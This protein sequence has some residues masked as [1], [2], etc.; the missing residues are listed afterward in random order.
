MAGPVL[1]L[2]D[3]AKPFEAP[4]SFAYALTRTPSLNSIPSRSSF[5]YSDR[6]IAYFDD[7]WFRNKSSNQMPFAA[8]C[9]TKV[10]GDNSLL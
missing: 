6:V 8:E 4:S 5:L 7:Y 3:H 1:A 9:S 2:P 10:S